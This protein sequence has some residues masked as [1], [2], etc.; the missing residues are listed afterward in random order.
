MKRHASGITG[1]PIRLV[2]FWSVK[3]YALVSWA[4]EGERMSATYAG[5]VVFALHVQ[6][7]FVQHRPGVVELSYISMFEPIDNHL[8]SNHHEKWAHDFTRPL[9]EEGEAHR[10]D[11]TAWRRRK[12]PHAQ[13]YQ[14]PRGDDDEHQYQ[15]EP[16]DDIGTE[17]LE[18]VLLLELFEDGG[19]DLDEL[20][21]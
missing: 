20:H 4:R 9:G 7:A 11:P 19:L 3:A 1:R 8:G 15:L 2:R 21:G 17:Q 12:R 18:Q 16:L 13:L 14:V 5:V 6:E 10:E